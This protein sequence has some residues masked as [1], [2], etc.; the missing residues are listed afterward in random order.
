MLV[1]SKKRAMYL[2]YA[3]GAVLLLGAVSLSLLFQGYRELSGIVQVVGTIAIMGI[4]ARM[5]CGLENGD[6]QPTPAT[7]SP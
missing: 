4:T 1:S 5:L 7:K 3:M 6:E 2:A